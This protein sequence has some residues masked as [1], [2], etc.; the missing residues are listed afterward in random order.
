M[1]HHKKK[2]KMEDKEST[3]EFVFMPNM[4]DSTTEEKIESIIR[5]LQ[6]DKIVMLEGKLSETEKSILIQN[7]MQKFNFHFKGLEMETIDITPP[8]TFKSL[9]QGLLNWIFKGKFGFT[10]IGPASIVKKIKKDPN[11]LMILASKSNS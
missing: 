4:N 9:K 5:E 1:S 7:A 3:L 2:R 8:G 6:K 10:I 11:S